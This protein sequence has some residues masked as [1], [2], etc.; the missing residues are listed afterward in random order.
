MSA[1]T[2]SSTRAVEVFVPLLNEGTDVL[3]P[4]QGLLLADDA[5]EVQA[6]PDYNPTVEEWQFPPGSKVRCVTEIRNGR[7][8]L[9]A[10]QRVA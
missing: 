5:I 6:T 7:K 10:R 4:T 2:G 1:E 3:R 9:V 8:L